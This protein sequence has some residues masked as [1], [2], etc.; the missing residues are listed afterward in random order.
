M[1]YAFQ[2]SFQFFLKDL[3]R[4]ETLILRISG[5]NYVRI[6]FFELQVLKNTADLIC[7]YLK[8]LSI[9]MNTASYCTY[10]SSNF[11]FTLVYLLNIA[12]HWDCNYIRRDICV[13]FLVPSFIVLEDEKTIK[14]W[15]LPFDNQLHRYVVGIFNKLYS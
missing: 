14:H 10:T 8:I 3:S 4:S 15:K 6:K 9:F 13:I 12:V 5:K 2:E 11:F 7:L 1:L